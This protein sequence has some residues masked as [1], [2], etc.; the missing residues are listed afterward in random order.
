MP[1]NNCIIDSEPLNGRS[2]HDA[3]RTLLKK[4]YAQHIGGEMPEILV[5][6]RGKPYFATGNVHFSISHTKRHV[7]CVLANREVGIDAEE[8]DR[9]VSL[10][11]AAKILSAN[12]LVQHDAA[13]D[14]NRALL[15]FWVLKEAAVKLSGEGLRG[16]PN[17]TNFALDDPRVF[18]TDG[19]LVAVILKEEPHAL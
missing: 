4:L 17:Q 12:E 7:F 13:E 2:G 6:D 16:F 1:M 18:E 15:T 8:L 11:L 3:G 19:C 10:K 5:T 14:K 9:G